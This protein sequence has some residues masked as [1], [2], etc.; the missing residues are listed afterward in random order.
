MTILTPEV[1]ARIA[2]AAAQAPPLSSEQA[3]RLRAI[4]G[5]AAARLVA[6][7]AGD[8]TGCRPGACLAVRGDGGRAS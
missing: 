7:A 5:P 1:R 3:R 8:H 4:W 2:A 6:H